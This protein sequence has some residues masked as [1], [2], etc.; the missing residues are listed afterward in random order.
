MRNQPPSVASGRG[1]VEGGRPGAIVFTD[2][3]GF[4]EF[5]ALRGDQAALDLLALQ[6]R[7]VR[8][9]VGWDGR[10][11]KELGDGLMLWFADPCRAVQIALA[12]QESFEEHAAENDLPLWVRIGIHYGSPARRGND[13]VGHDVNLAARIVDLA[14]PGEV[15][16]SAAVVDKIGASPPHIRFEEVGPA[17]M[18]G[19][20]QPVSLYRAIRCEPGSGTRPTAPPS[21]TSARAGGAPRRAAPVPGRRRRR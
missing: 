5:T 7:L 12:L 6:E 9:A 19:I 2:L 1:A 13:L 21:P 20:P 8:G 18:K 10:I 4:T 3:A 14:A 11:V 15:L 17:V 16:V